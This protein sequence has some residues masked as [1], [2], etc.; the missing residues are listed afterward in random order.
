MKVNK[1]VRRVASVATKDIRPCLAILLETPQTKGDYP[2]RKASAVALIAEMMR[3]D[4]DRDQIKE[5]LES[6]N[7]DNS[8][9]L[10]TVEI[11]TAITNA[12]REKYEYSCEHPILAGFCTGSECPYDKHRKPPPK[13][14]R[15]FK[16]LDYCWP[17]ILTKRQVLIYFLS[18]PYLEVKNR[19]GPGGLIFANHMQIAE[20]AGLA[21]KRVGSDL[22]TLADAGL[23]HYTPGIP[24]VWERKAS[25]VRRVIPI[26]PPRLGRTPTGGP[27]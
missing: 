8:P 21:V 6:W 4:L 11:Q 17:Q 2:G 5:I 19:V 13:K 23:I 20:I 22:Q 24:R 10:T 27:K 7:Q 12:G 1:L 25:E 26:P 15:N 9:P 18:I 14:V 16:F 3:L